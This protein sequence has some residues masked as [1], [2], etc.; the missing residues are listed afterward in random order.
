MI[1]KI[2][3]Y[4]YVFPFILLALAN[5]NT[6]T[7]AIDLGFIIHKLF[8]NINVGALLRDVEDKITSVRFKIIHNTQFT[9]LVIVL[10]DNK[11]VS[12]INKRNIKLK[13][14]SQNLFEWICM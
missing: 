14:Y 13:T 10:N 2:Y 8:R 1:H 9:K 11:I 12:N 6:I 4:L 3:I 5:L 7:N